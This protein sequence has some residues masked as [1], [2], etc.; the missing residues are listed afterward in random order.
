[1]SRTGS[2]LPPATSRARGG[3]TLIEVLVTTIILATGI[4]LVLQAFDLGA[5]ALGAARDRLWSGLLLQQKMAETRVALADGDEGSVAAVASGRFADRYRDFRWERRCHAETSEAEGGPSC[6]LW[7]IT[8]TV[9]RDGSSRRTTAA[10]Y[11]AIM[12][13]R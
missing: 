11:A 5:V 3:F 2:D 6:R 9:W 12:E 4:V 10:T 8:M 7:D 1:M 13:D